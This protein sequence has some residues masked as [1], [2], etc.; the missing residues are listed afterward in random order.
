MNLSS[1]QNKIVSLSEFLSKQ[2]EFS[3]QKKVVFTNGCFDLI[4]KGHISYL[5]EAKN[6]GDLLVLGLNTDASIKRLKGEKRP[7]K[8]QD[9][10]ALVL[11]SFS[12][13]DYVILF[14]EDTP[15]KLIE[16]IS[17]N[18]L[19]K[20]ADYKKENVIGADIVEENGGEVVLISFV[21][22]ASSTNLVTKIEKG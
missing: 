5:V 21:E 20:G 11:A 4:H 2:S 6:L 15:I 10:R 22:G 1:I 19:V 16:S 12:F 14:N 18:I 9:T 8:D 17:P 3:N 13:V 7:I